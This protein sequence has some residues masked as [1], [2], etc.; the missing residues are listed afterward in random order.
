MARGWKRL[1]RGVLQHTPCILTEALFS[2]ASPQHAIW[3]LQWACMLGLFYLDVGNCYEICNFSVTG[4]GWG[5]LCTEVKNGEYYPDQL[6]IDVPMSELY[7]SKHSN[8]EGGLFNSPAIH[9]RNLRV[10]ASYRVDIMMVFSNNDLF[11][12]I[13]L[14]QTIELFSRFDCII[15]SMLHTIGKQIAFC[16]SFWIQ[17]WSRSDVG[18]PRGYSISPPLYHRSIPV[19]SQTTD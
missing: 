17:N 13:S 1:K 5:V 18:V 2:F 6:V 9:L 10:L 8:C 7:M 3:I 16:M 15:P 11:G 19:L 12:V 14:K 4:S